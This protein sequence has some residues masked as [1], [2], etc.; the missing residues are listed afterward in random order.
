MKIDTYRMGEITARLAERVA[1]LEALGYELAG[2]EF[3]LGRPSR[4]R[5]LFEQFRLTSGRKGKTSYSTDAKVLRAIRA[6]HEIVPVI[7]EWRELSKLL[8]TPRPADH[9]T[10]SAPG[11]CTRRSTR[12][13]PRLAGSTTSPNSSRS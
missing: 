3:M 10:E 8:N 4:S 7:E 13:S 5:V 12:R 6:E 2:E 1:E 9:A 11:G